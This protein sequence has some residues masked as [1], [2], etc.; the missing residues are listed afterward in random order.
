MRRGAIALLWALLVVI[1]LSVWM[2]ISLRNLAVERE[3]MSRTSIP[4][5]LHARY[6]AKAG[7][8]ETLN[9]F[10]RQDSQPVTAFNPGPGDSQDPARGI[11][12]QQR[13][14]RNTFIGYEVL[15]ANVR[16]ISSTRGYLPGTLWE[17]TSIGYV[18]YRDRLGVWHMVRYPIKTEIIRLTL[19]PPVESAVVA[20]YGWRVWVKTR[21]RVRG[22]NSAG[23]AVARWTGRPR[24]YGGTVTGTP[25]FQYISDPERELRP[26]EYYRSAVSIPSVFGISE[27]SVRSVADLVTGELEDLPEDFSYLLVYFDGDLRLTRKPLRGTGVLIV[28]G[29]LRIDNGGFNYFSGL[30]YV[31]GNVW[32]RGNVLISGSL[33]LE[34]GHGDNVDLQGTRDYVE[35]TYDR[36]IL[37]QVR[38]RIGNYR[39]SAAFLPDESVE[40]SFG[41]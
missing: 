33:V 15:R 28:N 16:D 21:A 1:M 32:I 41:F 5:Q 34:E 6:M 11:V 24:V 9:W 7:L 36:N 35:I 25:R 19:A 8:V 39:F 17:L 31:R 4:L 10:R 2:G 14:M 38:A 27:N 3:F 29:D 13:I 26:V 20:P 23:I 18:R 37:N 22:G 12:F 40:R 30:I